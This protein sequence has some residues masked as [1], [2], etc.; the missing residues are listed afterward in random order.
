MTQGLHAAF[1]MSFAERSVGPMVVGSAPFQRAFGPIT[2]PAPIRQLCG[3]GDLSAQTDR[4]HPS[5]K[6]RIVPNAAS[7]EPRVSSLVHDC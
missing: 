2:H 4:F 7:P 3:K 5:A 1:E 6:P